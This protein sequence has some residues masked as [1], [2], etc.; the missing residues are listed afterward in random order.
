MQDSAYNPGTPAPDTQPQSNSDNS[1]RNIALIAVAIIILLIL[2]LLAIAGIARG[3]G[4]DNPSADTILSRAK[5]ATVNDANY[6]IAAQAQVDLG[7]VLGSSAGGSATTINVTGDGMLT[8]SPSRN[9]ATI[10]IPL[11]GAQNSINV[12]ADDTTLYLKLPALAGLLGGGATP[13][14]TSK[15]FKVPLGDELNGTSISILDY[16]NLKSVKLIGSE[17]V[18]DKQTWHLQGTFSLADAVPAGASATATAVATSTGA[19]I[20]NLTEDLWIIQD[21]YFPAKIMLQTKASVPSGSTGA[22]TTQSTN[23]ITLTFTKWN[24]GITITP[25]PASDVTDLPTG[26]LPGI[27]MATPTP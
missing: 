13:I 10:V 5:A 26:S 20:G 16:N 21:N 25:P 19:D 27:P 6:S 14:D 24:S 11:L 4:S 15:W 12:I 17:K 7:S 1:R 2:I 18:G 3:R 22:S 8:N 9:E 23:V